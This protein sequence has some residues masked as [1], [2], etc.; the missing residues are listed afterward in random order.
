MPDRPAQIPVHVD[1]VLD[2]RVEAFGD[3]PDGIVRVD[4]YVLFV[5]EVIPGERVRVVVSSAARK[6]GR[7]ELLEVLEP[8][9]DRVEPRCPHFHHCGGCQL[10]HLAHPA[11]M[12][13][14][15]ERLRRVIAHALDVAPASLP[16]RPML[17]P[18][19]PWEQRT[20]LA[21]HF[22]ERDGLL[23]A[24]YFARRSRDVVG[25][26]ECPIQDPLALRVGLAVRDGAIAAGLSAVNFDPVRELYRGGHLRATVVRAAS[27]T[28][29]AHATVVVQTTRGM[30]RLEP[31]VRELQAAGATGASL[32][33]NDG[34]PEQ[35]LGER[36]DTLFGTP[37]VEDEVEGLRLRSSPGAFFQ[38]S[39]FGVTTLVREVRRI[40][41][42]APKDAR[43]ADLYCGGGLFALALARSTGRVFGIEDSEQAI[44]DANASAAL[45]GI[46]NA[47]FRAGLVERLMNNLARSREKPF[48]VILDPPRAGC[49]ARV[50][51]GVAK[52]LQPTRIVYVSCEPATLARD[53]ARLLPLGYEITE[54]TPVDMFPHTSHIETIVVLERTVRR[55]DRTA[56][57]LFER[58]RAD[59]PREG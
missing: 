32:N 49:A 14:K 6:Y 41:H 4:R 39:A 55:E 33:V 36:F 52:E 10:Q 38:T 50:L 21:L 54:I 42:D 34:P 57:R 11:Q 12:L 5:P 17:G 58:L 40:L 47:H 53:L 46:E 51:H 15:S 19:V 26:E 25:I 3:G 18:V 48:A 44:A 20:K 9:P 56:R 27:A 31:L 29:Q 59:A 16:I 30:P 28:G 7:A 8:S 43:I 22:V 2:A 1:D 24:G 37:G 35:L 45:N 23:E 13:E